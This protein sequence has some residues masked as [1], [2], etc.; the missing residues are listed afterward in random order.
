V[1]KTD[2][3]LGGNAYSSFIF[4]SSAQDCGSN[5]IEIIVSSDGT[6]SGMS[7]RCGSTTLATGTWY[8]I[9]AVYDASV[10]ALHVYLNGVNNDGTLS[11]TVPSSI[12]YS[13]WPVFVGVRDPGGGSGFNGL[14]DE[15]RYYNRALSATEISNIYTNSSPTTSGLVG[16]WKLDE[17]SGIVA[18]DSSGN[19]NNGSIEDLPVWYPDG[20][21][22]N[23]AIAFF[24][25]YSAV[26][27]TNP[28]TDFPTT[29]S[30][31]TSAW[32]YVYRINDAD[33]D[34]MIDE[35]GN[36]GSGD[37]A[38]EF[39]GSQDCTGDDVSDN[40]VLGIS[41]DGNTD[42]RELC[43]N[44]VLQTNTWYF[45]TGVYDASVPTEHVY[46]NGVLD[47]GTQRDPVPSA[48]HNS[49]QPFSVGESVDG[50][51]SFHG[52]ID[53]LRIYDRALS[54]AE[55][56]QL[57]NYTRSQLFC[58]NPTQPEGSM[59][60]NK[61]Y[62]I[63]QYCGGTTWRPMGFQIDPQHPTGSGGGC[64]SPSG[65]EGDIIFDKK[66]LTLQYCD[67]GWI[68]V[69]GSGAP[70]SGL[71]GYWN[72]DESSGPTANDSSG[73]G[74][75]GTWENSPTYTASGKINGALTFNGTNQYVNIAN[76]SNF[77]FERT[78]PF[79]I[80]AWINPAPSGGGDFAVVGKVASGTGY[81]MIVP[82][83][84][85]CNNSGGPNSCVE[86][87]LNGYGGM[88]VWS[89][90]A[91]I[92]AGIWQHI[93]VTYDGS[94]N[95]SGMHIYING[96]DQ[97]VSSDTGSTLSASILNSAPLMIGSYQGYD[98]FDGTIDDVRVYNRAL[99]A[100]EVQA[101]YNTER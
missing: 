41:A 78:Q 8:H 45:V 83:G 25:G 98:Y 19:G 86:F 64:S 37:Q 4:Q 24:D 33:G 7:W 40:L 3:D 57:Y 75:D 58:A 21:K 90:I 76:P 55:V 10:P 71:V 34:D 72:L 42:I 67:G 28:L 18:S 31:T 22:I 6:G 81:G 51:Q 16:Y 26:Q 99:N 100:S 59:M 36:Y 27:D 69:G 85:F 5:S 56:S 50:Y 101:L 82:G 32:I 29:G 1:S 79:S 66:S 2:A 95:R 80:T 49:S 68:T 91:T 23:G 17:T 38:F 74:N 60:Y 39:K 47:D 9:A 61:D 44:T 15:L 96:V 52:L 20:G 70:T 12:F 87:D 54:G 84:T 35:R 14:V 65:N 93:A 13:N 63:M 30:F 11:G 43:G 73:N 48:M 77:S 88:R 46:I 62:H 89:G 97:T 92:T 53:D 94:S